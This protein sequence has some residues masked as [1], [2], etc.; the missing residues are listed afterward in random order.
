MRSRTRMMQ[1]EIS[2]D[3]HGTHKYGRGSRI[4]C[5]VSRV[6]SKTI[7]PLF[8]FKTLFTWSGGPGLVG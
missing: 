2:R 6:R 8:F 4:L 5:S 1:V 7:L 3:E